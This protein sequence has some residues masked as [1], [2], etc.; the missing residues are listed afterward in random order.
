MTNDL[1]SQLT[2]SA[3]GTLPWRKGVAW[4]VVLLQGV[5]LLALGLYVFFARPTT[6]G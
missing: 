6:A 2:S 4:W 5:V 1:K 3:K